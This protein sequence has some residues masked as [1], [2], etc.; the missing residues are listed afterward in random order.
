MKSSRY[1]GVFRKTEGYFE[2][3]TRRFG[4][5][6][7]LGVFNTEHEAAGIRDISRM[8]LKFHEGVHTSVMNFPARTWHVHTNLII[9]TKCWT[10][11]VHTLQSVGRGGKD[12]HDRRGAPKRMKFPV[13]RRQPE[14]TEL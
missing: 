1:R 12:V 2:A 10:T 9:A 8:W 6:Y 4:K 3:Q 7:S 11:F 5:I 13:V 14:K